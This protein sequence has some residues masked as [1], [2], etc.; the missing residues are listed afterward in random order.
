MNRDNVT[1]IREMKTRHTLKTTSAFTLMELLVVIAIIIVVAGLVVG[2]GGVAGERK[3]VSRAQI[4]RDRLV[5]LIENYKAQIGVYPPD[6]TNDPGKN[7]LFYE[8]AGAFRDTSTAPP[9]Y[10]TRFSLNP[11]SGSV[12]T[13]QFGVDG[14]VN[15][16]DVPGGDSSQMK[17]I[18]KDIRRDQTNSVVPGTFSFV[19]PVDGPNGQP[20]PWKYLVGEHANHNKETFDLWVEIV[21]RGKT[22][23]IGNW[24][25]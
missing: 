15:A 17:L 13:S 19:V 5:T 22:N 21:V 20:N 11:V 23:T 12:L 25:D 24:K 7:T 16:R 10:T 3:K 6:N 2:L 9:K 18:L 14:V 1:S 4:E 8:L